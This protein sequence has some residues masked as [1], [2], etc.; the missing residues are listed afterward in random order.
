MPLESD[1][2]DGKGADTR[3]HSYS[4]QD[5]VSGFCSE[6]ASG[7][8]NEDALMDA[9][10]VEMVRRQ[11]MRDMHRQQQTQDRDR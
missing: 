11:T 8:R 9:L 2:A 5:S 7:E 3:A 6:K 4:V 10:P 1:V